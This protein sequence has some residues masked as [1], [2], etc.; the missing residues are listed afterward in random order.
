MLL[1]NTKILLLVLLLI[2]SYG[3]K[4]PPTPPLPPSSEVELQAK[5]NDMPQNVYD[6][7]KAYVSDNGNNVD[8]ALKNAVMDPITE[9]IKLGAVAKRDNDITK[10]CT[11]SL[12]SLGPK[13]IAL[14]PPVII[15]TPPLT[16]IANPGLDPNIYNA[17]ANHNGVSN[18]IA[19]KNTAIPLILAAI[20]TGG[21]GRNA[22]IRTAA[23]ALDSSGALATSIITFAGPIV[24]PFT[25]IANPGL[26]PNIYN[27]IANHNGVS[28]DIAAKNTA[29]PL[30]HNA[31]TAGGPGRNAAITA[32]CAAL[33]GLD[34]T[35][36]ARL[37][38]VATPLPPHITKYLDEYVTDFGDD[39][40]PLD[41]KANHAGSAHDVVSD[42]R[43]QEF[44]GRD[45]PKDF[46]PS[47]RTKP[48]MLKEYLAGQILTALS[49]PTT[50]LCHYQDAL[51]NIKALYRKVHILKP[52]EVAN[53]TIANNDKTKGG[54]LV[55]GVYLQ[56][57]WLF[58]IAAVNKWLVAHNDYNNRDFKGYLISSQDGSP[59]MFAYDFKKAGQ[60][61][62]GLRNA[63]QG[64]GAVLPS[65]SGLS[66]DVL[67]NIYSNPGALTFTNNL[68]TKEMLFKFIKQMKEFI[69]D[70][71][72]SS[73][74]LKIVK[75][76]LA[77]KAKDDLDNTFDL[78]IFAAKI[79]AQIERLIT[80][81]E[82]MNGLNVAG[83]WNAFDAREIKRE[84]LAQNLA[85]SVPP[86]PHFNQKLFKLALL[87]K[88]YLDDPSNAPEL[89][90]LI[91]NV[92]TALT[93]VKAIET[94][95]LAQL[96]SGHN[97]HE[98]LTPEIVFTYPTNKKYYLII[99]N[100]LVLDSEPHVSNYIKN[101]F[102]IAG[103]NL[104][105]TISI[106]DPNIST[107]VD[108]AIAQDASL[109]IVG[110][111][112]NTSTF[113]IMNNSELP[114]IWAKYTAAHKSTL[115]RY[116]VET[117]RSD[118]FTSN[119]LSTITLKSYYK[120]VANNT[121]TLPNIYDDITENRYGFSSGGYIGVTPGAGVTVTG[122]HGD[123]TS[124]DNLLQYIIDHGI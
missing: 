17:I 7:I 113:N 62:G 121:I 25:L 45:V 52:T 23:N 66:R 99:D 21:P 73:V 8:N 112:D 123:T 28:N 2:A 85:T 58:F 87:G 50:R 120:D 11:G 35:I 44:F 10:A 48:E 32:A 53:I 84:N 93:G 42:A 43:C 15:N 54:V 117:S 72:G 3:C 47:S 55:D 46:E 77:I 30:I 101:K 90:N 40:A 34:V 75:S 95:R 104:V 65:A 20:T 110:G 119:E 61:T 109:I 60:E 115:P 74:L 98:A 24:V 18:D 105:D 124:I 19:A 38:V 103:W 26:D 68:M 118:R 33:A 12:S 116:I 114:R 64:T 80:E 31:I 94:A 63:A 51:G 86:I 49:F 107:K 97:I 16:L 111:F 39:A 100:N 56:P 22:A 78:D 36:I 122:L 106:I 67:L 57:I 70:T 13:I 83:A 91:A 37:P 88:Y 89:D 96:A 6:V 14:L 5:P 76:P 69:D 81:L 1:N 59:T 9:A 108:A 71:S 79:K 41:L 102:N 4:N 92:N 29:I 27:A 82:N